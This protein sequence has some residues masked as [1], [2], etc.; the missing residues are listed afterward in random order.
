MKSKS[1][2]TIFLLLTFSEVYYNSV[3]VCNKI[4][5]RTSIHDQR[6]HREMLYLLILLNKYGRL[7]QDSWLKNS[8][9]LLVSW[10]SF[11]LVQIS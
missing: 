8:E 3:H 4:L 10:S 7:N 5:S 2:L 11:F 1:N 9:F 6:R